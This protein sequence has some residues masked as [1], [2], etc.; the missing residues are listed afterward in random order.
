VGQWEPERLRACILISGP[1]DLVALSPHMHSRGLSTAVM[2]AIFKCAEL[3][4]A[5]AQ[6]PPQDSPSTPSTPRASTDGAALSAGELRAVHKGR[7]TTAAVVA[8]MPYSSLLK[9]DQ[10]VDEAARRLR[11]CSPALLLELF[12]RVRHPDDDN[13]LERL[14]KVVLLHGTSDKTCP[15][16]QSQRFRDALLQAGVKPDRCVLKLYPGKTHTSPIIEDPM[17]GSDP[18]TSDL[19]DCIHGVPL[20]DGDDVRDE[21]T[22][23]KQRVLCPRP[24]IE[25]ARLVGPF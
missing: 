13:G 12:P 24:L 2:S 11:A 4:E 1:L 23:Y 7:T 6:A 10:E 5:R 25:F 16:S 17:S 3:Q 18:L 22:V 9:T 8:Q 21:A 20:Q 19:L 15:H 14:P